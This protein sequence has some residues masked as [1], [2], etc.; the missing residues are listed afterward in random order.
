MDAPNSTTTNL[1]PFEWDAIVQGIKDQQCI[2]CIGPGL[3]TLSDNSN[4]QAEQLSAYLR[5][6]QELLKIRVQ[7]NGWFHLQPGG[8]DGPAYQAIRSFY[9]KIEP[10]SKE[11]L[12]MLTRLKFHF[13]LS[14]TPDLHL[15][16][17]FEGQQLPYRFDAYVRN[18]PDRNTEAPTAELPMVYNLLGEINNRNSLVLTFDDF[19]DYLESVFKGNSMSN[20]LKNNILDAQYFLFIGIPFD[21][22]FVH[23]FMR[24]LRQHKEPRTRFAT[25]LKLSKEELESTAEQYN[26]KFIDSDITAFVNELY[27]RCEQ[28]DLVKTP[29]SSE[30]K[31]DDNAFFNELYKAL[32]N[33]EFERISGKLKEVL[34]GVGETGKP[35]LIQ[36]IQLAGRFNELKEHESLG[37]I[38]YDKQMEE[39]NKIRKAYI[40]LIETLQDSWKTLNIRL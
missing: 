19:Y 15:R 18:M 33:N 31:S 20:M 40:D 11:L 28:E 24:I 22:W 30:A 2:V 9:K 7:N 17:A 14:L 8:S 34:R 12:E 29:E 5:Q 35:Y 21:Q 38:N 39:T 27:Q 10:D 23:L 6:H 25:G 36:V 3:F 37:I 16:Q 1:T 26:I 4:E 13:L 32:S